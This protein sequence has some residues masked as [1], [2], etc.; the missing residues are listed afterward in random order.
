MASLAT[1]E[2]RFARLARTGDEERLARAFARYAGKPVEYA[3]D[4]LGRVLTPKQVEILDALERPPHR[5]LARSANTQ[6][7]TFVAA[8]K[9]SHF[10]DTA[11]P[12][13][14]LAT[15]PTYDQVR[16]LLFRE[17]RTLRRSSSGFLPKDTRLQDAPDHFVHGISTNHPDRFQGRHA[18][19][20]GLVFDEATGIDP[21]FWARGETM[22]ESHGGHWWLCTYNPN[23]SASP[24]YLAEES[25][26]WALVVLSALEHPNVLAELR[27]DPPPIPSAV[28]LETLLRRMAAECEEVPP[29]ATPDPAEHFEFPVGSGQW[30]RPTTPDFEAQILGRWP[31]SPTAALFSPFLAE[32][33]LTAAR[34]VDPLWQIAVGCDVARFGDDLTA[35][36]VRCGPCLL[37]LETHAKVSTTWVADRLRAVVAETLS[38]LGVDKK[39]STSIPILVDDTGGY[40]AGV[41]DQ[42]AGFNAVGVN[43]SAESPDP[44][45]PNTRTYLWCNLA[46]LARAGALDLSRLAGSDRAAVRQELTAARYWVDTRGR[47]V[48]EPKA[49]VKERLRRSPDR[50]DAVGLAYYMAAERSE[51]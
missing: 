42:L 8:L 44:R 35:I 37:S 14:T 23:D 19:R 31:V 10:Y 7:K 29:H 22:F 50:V 25:G 26:G 34:Q 36:A 33:C 48:V 1:L 27:G 17:L 38:R 43:A 13:I 15:A 39:R 30:W 11:R 4:H 12:S 32:Q 41:I 45:F 20:L 49:H 3:R 40:G 21:A 46:N 24:A 51:W 28:R 18:E 2:R 6:G 5:V 47:R 16:D 9:C